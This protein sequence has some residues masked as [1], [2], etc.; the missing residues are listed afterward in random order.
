MS[1]SICQ[2]FPNYPVDIAQSVGGLSFGNDPLVCGGGW[3]EHSE[4][5]A[6]EDN[7]WK[8]SFL[9]SEA[10]IS[11]TIIRSPFL[12][13]EYQLII[14]GGYIY[15]SSV[16]TTEALTGGGWKKTLP[17]LPF[18]V[19]SHCMTQ[20]NSTS[21]ITILGQR[22]F[23]LQDIYK[24]WVDGPLL[25]Y[26]RYGQSCGRIRKNKTNFEFSII[27]VGGNN[28]TV[29]TS[30]EIFDVG[31]SIWHTGPDL[32]FGIYVAEFIEDSLG[33]VILIGGRSETDLYVDSLFRLDNAGAHW[34]KLP[35][36]LSS[37]RQWHA[38][39]LIPD[40]LTNCSIN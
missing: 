7:D 36:K 2:K 10:K 4:C 9:M 17:Q 24:G 15:N 26:D 19:N 21:I 33:G 12:T 39:F 31:T 13:E 5:F 16:N 8:P 1:T 11:S 27:V 40:H 23:I 14:S 30:T 25:N 37:G 20:L 28:G 3:P 32:P 34:E 38:A 22:T 18:S 35:Q 6:Y 29:M